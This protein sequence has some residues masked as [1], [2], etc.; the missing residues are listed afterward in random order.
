MDLTLTYNELLNFP[1]EFASAV[2]KSGIDLVSTANNHLLDK[3]KEGALRT[4]DV[5]DNVGL[6]HTGSYRNQKAHYHFN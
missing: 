1:D 6:E 5:L 3:G 4:L 2:K